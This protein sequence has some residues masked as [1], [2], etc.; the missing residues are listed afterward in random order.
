MDRGGVKADEVRPGDLTRTLTTEGPDPAWV[1]ARPFRAH[2]R[3]LM[4][5]GSLDPGELAVV[6]GLSTVGVRHLLEGRAGRP[7]RRISPST[8]R[9]L[10]LVR[11]DDVR[12]L[13]CALTPT[14]AVW[15]ALRRLQ[16]AG[17]STAEVATAVG[18]GLP[19]LAALEV[20]ERCSRL[21][22]VRLLGLARR[23]PGAVD[24]DLGPIRT[25]A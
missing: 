24:D 21:L 22:A 18:F 5:A 11:P 12:G 17:W 25:A 8:A 14:G 2:L 10:L 9:R 3:L 15:E 7:P 20:D 23:L 4:A 19:A 16:A 1:D 6:L 13:R